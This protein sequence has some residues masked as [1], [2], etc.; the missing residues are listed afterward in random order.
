MNQAHSSFDLARVMFGIIFISALLIAGF[1]IVQPFILGFSWAGMVVIATWPLLIKLQAILWGKRSLAVLMMTSLLVLLFVIPVGLLINSI[2]DT[3]PALTNLASSKENFAVPQLL[4]LENIPF[5]GDYLSRTWQA[6]IADGGKSLI[7]KVQPYAGEA[8]TWILAQVV[9]VGHFMVHA[10]LMVVFSALLY[11]KGEAVSDSVKHF[12]LR[13]SPSKGDVVVTLAEQAIRAVALGVVVTALTQSIL[14]GI[15]LAVSGVGYATVLTVVMFVSCL[16]QLGPLPILIPAIIWLYWSGDNTWGTIL[17]IWSCIVGTLDNFIRPALIRMGADLPLL[18][19][20]SGVIGGM[21]AF[22]MIGLF[23]G[24]VVLAVGYRLLS[25]WVNEIKSSEELVNQ[26]LL[27]DEPK[28][29]QKN[30]KKKKKK[31]K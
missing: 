20:L 22:G 12:A 16:A 31:S 7:A 25:A 17:L 24:P 13:L 5:I 9:H 23:I 14:G 3:A 27:V 28:P 29:I 10:T 30:I 19:I 26:S 2:V 11:Y 4:W 1:W 15:G 18:L 21:L 6:L 8:A